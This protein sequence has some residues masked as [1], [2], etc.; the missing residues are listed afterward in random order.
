MTIAD[1]PLDWINSISQECKETSEFVQE[2]LDKYGVQQTPNIGKPKRLIIKHL[3]FSGQKAG[4]CTNSLQFEFT[5]LKQ[6]L[7]GLFSDGNLKGKTSTIEIIRW[8]LRGKPSS[9]FQDGVKKWIKKARL[10]FLIDDQVYQVDINIDQTQEETYG[11]LKEKRKNDLLEI[12]RFY[13]ENAFEICMSDFMRKQ[14]SLDFISAWRKTEDQN[15]MGKSVIHDWSALSGILFIGGDYKCLFGDLIYDGLNNRLMNMYL[16]LPWVSTSSVLKTLEKQLSNNK[17]ILENKHQSK[18]KQQQ[19][20]RAFIERQLEISRSE[21]D[22][23][24]LNMGIRD[25]LNQENET[26]LQ[27]QQKAREL[28][29]KLN[30]TI[31]KRDDIQQSLTQVKKDY[32]YSQEAKAAI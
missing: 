27:A 31:G 4:K 16:G 19:E 13:S 29:K 18:Q 2:V 23:S 7:W 11:T 3:Q 9:N 17:T 26:Y 10:D 24:P 20:R 32:H 14:L 1:N 30:I 8:L 21:L 12:S 15:E 6:G 22:Q 5:E 25:H 28:N